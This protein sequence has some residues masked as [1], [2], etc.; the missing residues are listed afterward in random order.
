MEEEEK[1]HISVVVHLYTCFSLYSA[2]SV[3]TVN[4]L[5]YENTSAYPEI[6]VQSFLPQLLLIHV[7][8]PGLMVKNGL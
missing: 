3:H 2:L 5:I 7:E 4:V 8:P 1:S 6:K